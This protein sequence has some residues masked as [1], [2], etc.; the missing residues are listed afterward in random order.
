MFKV[1]AVGHEIFDPVR[2][3][4]WEGG[5][6]DVSLAYALLEGKTRRWCHLVKLSYRVDYVRCA[7]PAEWRRDLANYKVGRRGLM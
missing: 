7:H 2:T 4:M 1:E 3:V 5:S 6:V